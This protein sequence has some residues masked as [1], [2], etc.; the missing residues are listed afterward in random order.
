MGK[1]AID[2]GSPARTTPFAT[3]PVYGDLE[4]QLLKEVL[5]SG[6]WGGAGGAAKSNYE[7]KLPQM[8]RKFAE[9]QNAQYAVSVVN[10]TVAITVALQAAGLKPG[11]EV[12][13]PPYTFIATA[14]AALAYGIIPVFADIEEDTLLIDPEKV[15]ALITARTKGIIAVH[16]AGA[17]ANMT[18]LK[19]IAAKHGLALIEDAAQ[20]VGASW[21]GQG[22]GAIGDLGTFSLQSS[23]NLNAGE[24]GIITTNNRDYW[25]NAWSICNVGRVPNGGWYQHDRF[26]QNYRMSEFQAAVVMGQMT[27]LEEQMS[28]R[29]Q[30][31][32]LLDELLS[33]TKGIR[34]LKQDPRITRHAYHL[35]MFKLDLEQAEKN[36]FIRKANAEGVPLAAGYIPL[37]RNQSI[38]ETT[39]MW[40]GEERVYDC[41][42]CERLCEKEAV[43]L[44]Q[45]ILLSDEQA[46]RE[47]AHGLQKVAQS[48]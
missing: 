39:K 45:H 42:V 33:G 47:V 48:Y 7:P 13:V 20:A 11:D 27:R 36:D 32:K 34:L 29:E 4:M 5:E 26:G 43:W 25:E 30:N 31:A 22:I 6:K 15:E 8:E 21:E 16:I 19:E 46:I 44:T 1:L 3:W 40:T 14:S 35:Y 10:G 28:K 37:N 2:G 9:L 38:I 23:K 41:P 24:G 12:I 18:R 17:P